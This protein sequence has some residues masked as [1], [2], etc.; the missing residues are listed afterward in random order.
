VTGRGTLCRIGHP[1]D[2]AVA[3]EAPIVNKYDMRASQPMRVTPAPAPPAG[4]LPLVRAQLSRLIA[5]YGTKAAAEG[6]YLFRQGDQPSSAF[7][8]LRGTVELSV[9]S[10]GSRLVVQVLG[11]VSV[12]GD[13]PL[14]S[15][16]PEP[17]DARVLE[18]AEVIP[19][20][21]ENFLALL[22]D[23][24]VTMPWLVSV[25]TRMAALQERLI[26]VLGGRLE[27][28]LALL[29]L[30]Q[31][32]GNRVRLTQETLAG[33]LGVNRSSVNRCLR[34]L[35]DAGLVDIRYREIRL[36]DNDRL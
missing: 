34:H 18:S 28:R 36:V 23:P 25:A 2:L 33:L 31:A 21:A 11:P 10:Q 12:F 26:G 29:L 13:V 7:I 35:Q 14:V 27:D 15:R 5:N 20:P 3:G 30:Q 6:R 16:L 4:E 1:G 8:L 32:H 9:L 22:R 24:H 17:F 19:I